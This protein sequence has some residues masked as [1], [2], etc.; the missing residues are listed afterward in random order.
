MP[1]EGR[2]ADD[3]ALSLLILADDVTVDRGHSSMPALLGD[4]APAGKGVPVPDGR[5]KARVQ[6]AQ[7][8]AGEVVS[9][10]LR[11]ECGAKRAGHDGF[12]KPGLAGAFRVDEAPVR[13]AGG[14]GIAL[15]YF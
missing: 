5:A 11:Q 1:A 14:G 13:E 3:D 8:P 4:R 12:E 9:E 10:H 7:P 6:S 2:R 15:H